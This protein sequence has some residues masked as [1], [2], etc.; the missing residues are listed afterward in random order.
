MPYGDIPELDRQCEQCMFADMKAA[1]RGS[2]FCTYPGLADVESKTLL[3]RSARERPQKA[4][5]TR[6]AR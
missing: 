6:H 1:R 4:A 2:P 5:A 3:C